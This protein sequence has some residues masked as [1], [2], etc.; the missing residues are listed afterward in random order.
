M[1]RDCQAKASI[2]LK[3]EAQVMLLFNLDLAR[4]LCNGSR[5]VI[6]GYVDSTSY[7]NNLSRSGNEVP[8]ASKLRYWCMKNPRLPV[9]L[10]ANDVTMVIPPVCWEMTMDESVAFRTQIP[11]KLA[12]AVTV[13]KSQ[14]G[15]VCLESQLTLIQEL[16]L[17]QSLL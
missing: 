14:V 6:V 11:L 9:V 7:T 16:L 13:H 17:L 4:G 3:V 2:E 8:H 12:W 10:F 15:F 5:G 1:Q